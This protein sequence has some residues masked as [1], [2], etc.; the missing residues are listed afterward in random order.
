MM[1]RLAQGLLM[2]CAFCL[3]Q[4]III[5]IIIKNN[6]NN[7]NVHLYNTFHIKDVAQ[8]ASQFE[9]GTQDRDTHGKLSYSP[10]APEN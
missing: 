9:K 8:C 5:I 3:Y 7:N 2:E 10:V 1:T 6:N 4:S